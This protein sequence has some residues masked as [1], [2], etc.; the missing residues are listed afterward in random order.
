[1]VTTSI[2]CLEDGID[3][4]VITERKFKRKRRRKRKL[5]SEWL[6][7]MEYLIENVS[8]N[9]LRPIPPPRLNI[10]KMNFQ[11]SILT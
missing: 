3:G 11:L 5:C 4:R 8:D 7:V 9:G 10:M 2:F 1:M 6:V